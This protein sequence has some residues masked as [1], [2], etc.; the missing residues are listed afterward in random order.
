[1]GLGKTRQIIALAALRPLSTLVVAPKSTL[2]VW[3]QEAEKATHGRIGTLLWHGQD[4]FKRKDKWEA[5]GQIERF[6][7]I[8]TYDTLG[9]SDPFIIER[10][11][12][13]VVFDEAH[14]L[15]NSNTARHKNCMQLRAKARWLLTGT[16]IQNTDDDLRSLFMMLRA[17]P[18][19]NKEMFSRRINSEK[20]EAF[21]K[22]WILRRLK[23]CSADHLPQKHVS[24]CYSALTASERKF[25]DAIQAN[26]HPEFPTTCTLAKM[27][28]CRRAAAAA[29]GPLKDEL[30]DEDEHAFLSCESADES[31]QAA[32]GCIPPRTR[33]TFLRRLLKRV[34]SETHHEEDFDNENGS[35]RKMQV[36]T[37]PT[38]KVVIFSNFHAVLDEIGSMLEA[39]GKSYV[40]LDG[41]T[42]EA[43]RRNATRRFDTDASVSTFLLG[44]KA[45]G[46]GLNLQAAQVGILADPWWNPKAMSQAE[47]RIHRI[48]SPFDDI[49]IF[50]FSSQNTIESR[51][52]E[53]CDSKNIMADRLLRAVEESTR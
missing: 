45:G 8:T 35:K 44:L 2:A 24:S 13:R 25:Y 31:S 7:V 36:H 16:P 29:I 34:W 18:F 46:V 23:Q 50:R 30:E 9:S 26:E 12:G 4:R 39:M 40:R 5:S 3:Q 17:E 47:D 42:T 51:V 48:G 14:E 27:T 33:L 20:G 52:L 28:V 21:R 22:T 19:N 38:T 49:Y 41:N 37:G 6:L 10:E 11:W 43:E 32:S 53:V 15:R 1:M